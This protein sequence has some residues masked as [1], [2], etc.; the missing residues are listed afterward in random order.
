[1]DEKCN[2]GKDD[3]IFNVDFIFHLDVVLW[4]RVILCGWARNEPEAGNFGFIIEVGRF[5]ETE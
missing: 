1:M 2:D 4:S 3:Y 5:C